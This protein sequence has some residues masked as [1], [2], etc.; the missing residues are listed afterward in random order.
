MEKEKETKSIAFSLKKC[1]NAKSYK[2]TDRPLKMFS[3]IRNYIDPLQRAI[4]YICHLKPVII[5][6]NK[7]IFRSGLKAKCLG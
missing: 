2:Q 1:S 5:K 3:N 7:I 4:R 6:K